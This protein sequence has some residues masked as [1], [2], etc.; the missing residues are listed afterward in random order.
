[1]SVPDCCDRFAAETKFKNLP[2]HPGDVIRI[3]RCA[4]A[5]DRRR[6]RSDK[7]HNIKRRD[8]KVL[9]AEESQ[10]KWVDSDLEESTSSNSSS[11]SEQ[12][13]IQCLIADDSSYELISWR[14]AKRRRFNKVE[15]RRWYGQLQIQ[16]IPSLRATAVIREDSADDIQVE[17]YRVLLRSVNDSVLISWNDVVECTVSVQQKKISADSLL[18]KF[19]RWFSL[20]VE[21]NY[22][23]AFVLVGTTAYWLRVFSRG[24][25]SADALHVVVQQMYFEDS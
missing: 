12:E 2:L 19:S 10:S 1:M 17:F 8:R 3:C 24:I 9:V 13:E 16:Q 7:N 6:H 4:N 21:E 15:R 11:E 25:I 18:K 23:T 14:S 22:T 20:L 5:S